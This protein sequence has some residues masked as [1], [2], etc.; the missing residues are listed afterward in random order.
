MPIQL[1]YMNSLVIPIEKLATCPGIADIDQFI[2][3]QLQFGQRDESL[4]VIPG[5]QNQMDV[6]LLLEDYVSL[7][8]KPTR[9]KRGENWWNDLCVVDSSTGPTAPCEWLE[10][11]AVKVT[12]SLK[13][14]SIKPC[15]GTVVLAHGK[16]SGP[17]GSKLM[18]L[19][20]V[21][22]RLGFR[23]IRPDFRGMSD[24]DQRIDHLLQACRNVKGPLF[25]AGSS[26][27]GYVALKASQLLETTGLFLMAPAIGLSGY[28]DQ[29]PKP[30]CR[31]VCVVHAWQDEVIPASNVISWSELHQAELHL[32][33][34]DH[35]LTEK[36]VLL[37]SL[38]TTML[39][40]PRNQMAFAYPK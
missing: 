27:G 25:L 28:T 7:G 21:A 1:T 10:W 3:Q 17:D 20:N 23:V 19:A 18:A 40:R 39:K 37:K 16:E 13:E 38:F 4:L 9:K 30:G 2:D 8:L 33:E 11:D 35:R 22:S 32:V 29:S 24:P 26:M 15:Q 34:S 31:E 6:M 14:G 12:V 36:V 5:G